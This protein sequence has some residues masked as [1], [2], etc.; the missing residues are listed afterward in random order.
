MKSIFNSKSGDKRALSKADAENGRWRKSTTLF[1][2][3]I[4]GRSTI[5]YFQ[6]GRRKRRLTFETSKSRPGRLRRFL[7]L[8]IRTPGTPI[9][10]TINTNHD[11]PLINAR[12]HDAWGYSTHIC[13]VIKSTAKNFIFYC[14]N[15]R[16]EKGRV[17]ARILRKG[18]NDRNQ[19]PLVRGRAIPAPIFPVSAAALSTRRSR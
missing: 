14:G 16:W 15:A 11:R 12:L 7:R 3:S 2:N 18:I 10:T 19:R 4:W 13:V 6:V 1:R 17:D 8:S 5:A 9:K